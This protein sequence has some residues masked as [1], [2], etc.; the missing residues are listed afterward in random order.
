MNDDEVDV[1]VRRAIRAEGYRPPLILR[2]DSLRV[3][4][5]A[6]SAR[7]RTR[8]WRATTTA[9]IIAAVAV[10]AVVSLSQLPRSPS[11]GPASPTDRCDVS[12]VVEHGSW[13]KEIGGPNAF[14]NA[15]PDAFQ[16][17]PNNWLIITRFDP[18]ASP[19]QP[20]QMWADRLGSDDHIPGS[21]NSLMDPTNIYHFSDPAP[22]LP[23][24][25]Y[26]FEQRFPIP[27]CWQLTAAIDG[28]VVG[29]A[30]L[31]VRVGTSASVPVGTYMTNSAIP[32][33]P[34][35]A[36][37]NS[38]ATYE[39]VTTVRAWWWDQGESGD[40]QTRTSDVVSSTA[41]IEPRADSGYDLVLTIP[42]MTGDTNEIRVALQVSGGSLAGVALSSDNTS[43]FFMSVPAVE[44]EFAPRQ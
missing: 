17:E 31:S 3:R 12:T 35:F 38:R 25:W 34:C 6:D 29:T 24:G 36:F 39:K 44:P 43:V 41:D 22:Q 28:R 9:A 27:G 2:P 33:E 1:E 8:I 11:V 10:V 20:V 4:L 18:D 23:G 13:W 40:C 21:Y 14:F 7:R 32:G 5:E 37:E 15:E 42:R 30:T 26:L 19:G 16:A